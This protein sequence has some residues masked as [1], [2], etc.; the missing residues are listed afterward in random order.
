MGEH[1]GMDREDGVH[2][3]NGLLLSRKMNEIMP[4]AA[5]RMALE[6]AILSEV[7]HRET[8]PMILLI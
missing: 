2:I 6:F 7:R 4:L 5:A 8:D 3:Y 1:R